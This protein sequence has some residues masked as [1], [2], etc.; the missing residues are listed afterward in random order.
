VTRSAGAGVFAL[1][2][3]A[4]AC[5][6]PPPPGDG[7][8]ALDASTA[9]ASRDLAPPDD[10]SL[11]PP[12]LAPPP[13][14]VPY[15]DFPAWRQTARLHPAA[16][17]DDLLLGDWNHD[18][19]LD[20]LLISHDAMNTMATAAA[21]L[22]D[23]TGKFTAGGT[24]SGLAPALGD[25]AFGDV[26]G[27]GFPDLLD[28]SS[29]VLLGRGDGS[30]RLMTQLSTGALNGC[31]FGDFDG[32]GKLDALWVDQAPS[33]NC[34]ASYLDEL[35]LE[36]SPGRGDGTFQSPT[37][38]QTRCG[39]LSMQCA[40]HDFAGQGKPGWLWQRSQHEMR[41]ATS[42]DPLVDYQMVANC[43]DQSSFVVGDLDDD[44]RDD[45]IAC[46]AMNLDVSLTAYSNGD[47][48]FGVVSWPARLN[49]R[50]MPTAIGQLDGDGRRDMLTR[51]LMVVPAI[52]DE[53]V[54]FGNGDLTLGRPTPL[55]VYVP[56]LP[57]GTR[58]LG[59]FNGDGLDDFAVIDAASR[60]V[61]VLLNP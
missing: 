57:S 23:G 55:P 45:V 1:A 54:L 18:G 27:D 47:F 12:D 2:F 31:G 50:W 40:V 34:G 59:D 3:A 14:L 30:F 20:L 49:T 37:V 58:V 4:A 9:D 17:A 35:H 44:G 41:I 32:D 19:H 46:T 61:V 48:A 36:L 52:N 8:A 42:A 53:W 22:G 43:W 24:T 33:M 38:Y 13:D 6:S 26:D 29:Q 11:S 15:P 51:F 25:F 21:W 56:N 7:I 5:Q 16:P 39:G 60:D 10:L 28:D